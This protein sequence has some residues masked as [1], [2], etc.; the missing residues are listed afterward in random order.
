MKILA[1]DLSSV[2]RASWELFQDGKLSDGEAKRDALDRITR[3]REGF[4]RVVVACDVGP[5]LRKLHCPTY[6]G[7]RPDPGDAYRAMM[8]EVAER[9]V[10]DGAT[11]FPNRAE[12]ANIAVKVPIDSNN[13]ESGIRVLYPEADDVIASLVPWYR[14]RIEAA[15]DSDHVNTDHTSLRILSGDT[16]LWALVDDRFGI[17]VQRPTNGGDIATEKDVEARFGGVGTWVTEVKALA[18]DDGDGYSPFM[19]PTPPEPGKREGP[20]IAIKTA[21]KLLRSVEPHTA[22]QVVELAAD[23]NW[24]IGDHIRKCLLTARGGGLAVGYPCARMLTGLPLDFSRILAEPKVEKVSEL[25]PTSAARSVPTTPPKER[26]LARY[27]PTKAD[28]LDPNALQPQSLAELFDIGNMVVNSRVYPSVDCPEKAMMV[29]AE[30][31]ERRIPY[32]TALRNAYFVKGR[33]A[34]SAAF[35]SGLVQRSAVCE[36]FE[37]SE[38]TPTHAVVDYQRKGRPLRQFRFDLAEAERAGWTKQHPDAKG[39]PKW[40]TNP[41]VMLRWAALREAARFAFPDV[42]TGMYTPDELRDGHVLDAEFE[43]TED[44]FEGAS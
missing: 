27:E 40:I 9:L 23:E 18:G 31:R 29:I 10:K 6:K 36:V 5:S 4:D 1:V 12:Q 33:L 13:P 20:G 7:T 41:R 19:H 30:A 44:E 8:R 42:V 37:I 16:D 32:A 14:D 28:L 2:C 26:A 22:S 15:I 38:T 24:Q 17:D 25:R 3:A 43:Q 34:W 21:I 35:I 11:I 39:P